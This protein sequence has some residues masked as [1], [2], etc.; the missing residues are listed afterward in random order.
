MKGVYSW[1]YVDYKN[2]LWK[3]SIKDNG[4]LSYAVMYSE[5]KWTKSSIIDS[6]LHPIVYS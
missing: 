5:G 4:E 1:V 6:K 2:N 3:F